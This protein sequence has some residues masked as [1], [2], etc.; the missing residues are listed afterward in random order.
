MP[1]K[2]A[3]KM[4]GT[5]RPSDAG[6]VPPLRLLLLH[7]ARRCRGAEALHALRGD[8]TGTEWAL[9][10]A[11]FDASLKQNQSPMGPGGEWGGNPQSQSPKRRFQ[12]EDPKSFERGCCGFGLCQDLTVCLGT[13]ASEWEQMVRSSTSHAQTTKTAHADAHLINLPTKATLG[14]SPQA[15]RISLQ[16]YCQY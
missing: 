12:D 4:R 15:T 13:G 8:S 1:N 7:A 14:M 3:R 9:G 10:E 2:C 16:S 11:N 5:L 6:L